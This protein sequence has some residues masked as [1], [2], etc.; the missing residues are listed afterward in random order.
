[1]EKHQKSL[2]IS[3]VVLA[4]F[5][6]VQCIFSISLPAQ[7]RDVLDDLSECGLI[8]IGS[9]G[10]GEDSDTTTLK[11]RVLRRGEDSLDVLIGMG[12]EFGHDKSI[13]MRYLRVEA[14][15]YL[16]FKK[17]MS[18]VNEKYSKWTDTAKSEGIKNFKKKI[19]VDFG[20]EVGY[21]AFVL[22]YQDF[23]YESTKC[24]A[25]F[26][27]DDEGNCTLRIDNVEEYETNG[28]NYHRP[29]FVFYSP[30][31]FDALYNIISNVRDRY[32]QVKHLIDAHEKS[33]AERDAKFD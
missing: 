18:V 21:W 23:R 4:I 20:D 30:E 27:V 33:I 25:I 8:R 22:Y 29:F 17:N 14:K 3:I 26:E 28:T 1:M 12:Y 19:P 15:D 31:A 16:S 32:L 2:T 24:Y 7:D 6:F 11:V 10:T 9:F 13:D 5:Y